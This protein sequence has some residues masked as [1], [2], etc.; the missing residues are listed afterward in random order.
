MS[1]ILGDQYLRKYMSPNAGGGGIAVS[2][3]MST[4]LG[5]QNFGELT[6]YL[7]YAYT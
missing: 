2:R 5:A 1:S 7:T 3:P 4:A 6:P